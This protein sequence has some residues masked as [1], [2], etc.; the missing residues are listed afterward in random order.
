MAFATYD[1]VAFE[2][3]SGGA[4]IGRAPMPLVPPKTWPD[5][6]PEMKVIE[7]RFDGYRFRSRTEARW[8][9]FFKIAG[10][11]FEYEPQGFV[12]DGIPY[13]PDFWLPD[14][15]AWLEIKGGDPTE[16][17]IRLCEALSRQSKRQV[18]LASGPPK[19]EPQIRIFGG[20]GEWDTD[21]FY[22][23]DDRR[24]DGTFWLKDDEGSA[25][26]LI[27]GKDGSSDKHPVVISACRT[28]YEASR[29]ARF[30]DGNMGIVL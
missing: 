15:E 6:R 4:L 10:I 17:E 30:E 5:R 27:V 8:A 1:L 16:V 26:T 21:R 9:V 22:I 18:L 2:V 3:A 20:F 14:A 29:S 23:A 28:A 19:P 7:T 11:R 24:A 13:L 25:T 12:L